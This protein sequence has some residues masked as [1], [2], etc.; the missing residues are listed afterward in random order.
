L[1]RI[2]WN[3]SELVLSF[4]ENQ[5][6]AQ[7]TDIKL[8]LGSILDMDF[9][10][11]FNYTYSKTT[12][13]VKSAILIQ[14]M[15]HYLQTLGLQ[16]QLDK[17]SKEILNSLTNSEIELQDSI[18]VGLEIKNNPPTASPIPGFVRDLKPYQVG[19]ANHAVASLY[20]ANF[21]VPGSGKTAIAYAAFAML[22]A[23][24]IVDK[25]MV[26]GPRSSFMP[27]EEEYEACFGKKPVSL[28]VV[29]LQDNLEELV[30]ANELTLLTYQM[31]S[32]I[33][34][35]LIKLLCNH[36]FLLVLDESHH[37]KRFRG[38]MW[39]TSVLR[40]APYAKRRLILS[41]TPMP[42]SLLDLWTQFTFLWPFRN[43]LGESLAYQGIAESR[44]G[45]ERVRGMIQP[46]YTRI[47]KTQLNLPAPEFKPIEVPLN[48]VQK[49]I[50]QAL[51]AKTLS[52][53]GEI[54]IKDKIQLRQ[55]RQNKII[56]LLQAASNPSLLT[57]YSEEFRIP[58]LSVEGLSVVRLI[59]NYTQHEIP[60]KLVE[61]I[62]ITKQLLEKGEK[63]L[64]WTT[65]IHN[66]KTLKINLKKMLD[67]EPIM[68]FGEI[69]KDENEDIFFNREKLIREFKTD[70][71]PRVLIANP[72]SLAESVSLHKVCKNAIYVDRTFNAGQ[73]IQ[74]L[75]RIHRLGLGPNDV[76]TY[77]I[78]LSKGTIDAVINDRLKEKY[79]RMLK[80]LND[81]LP[82]IQLDTE[83]TEI[84]DEDF[85]RDFQAVHKYLL[86][87]QKT[88]NKV[89]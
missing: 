12:D 64:I 77:H 41:G 85:E 69:P 60:S 5:E 59:E 53:L 30:G 58:P 89:D 66:I 55:W 46:F 11:H 22:K 62:R 81:D 70:P 18:R 31:A 72:N 75:D 33:S 43:L 63:V 32:H 47:T 34:P 36:K 88:G 54:S 10:G 3:D 25:I 9:D 14:R 37:I 20:A 56:R 8:F 84:S 79:D 1:P 61:A 73:Y 87:S 26:I 86:E 4:E 23:Q 80:I 48:R 28:R 35:T 76:I 39:S 71:K 68:I 40:L 19:P 42:H 21:S 17:Q 2:H 24:G 74:S 44:G 49:A 6:V 50:Y 27:W 52:D 45:L 15:A 65:F 83:M 51:E 38:G 67:I 16:C 78:L 13:F 57:E 82:V 29:S 7:N